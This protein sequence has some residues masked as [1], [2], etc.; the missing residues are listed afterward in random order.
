MNSSPESSPAV[1]RLQWLDAGIAVV[2]MADRE[3]R[4]RFSE[5]LVQGLCAAF[6]RIEKASETRAVVVHGYDS[7]FCCGGT[8]EELLQLSSGQLQFTAFHYYDL[9]LR[10]SVP[11]IAAM[12]GH[13]IGG[14]LV[15]GAYA[16]LIVLAE[17]CIYCANFMDYGF[18]PGLGATA[19]IP[20]RFGEL[21][22]H[23][24]LLTAR[25]YH[26]GELRARGAPVR[27]T[28]RAHVIDEALMLARDLATK[29][30]ETLRQLKQAFVSAFRTEQET[31]V[32]RELRMHEVCFAD[33]R[34]RERI[35]T[36]Y[37]R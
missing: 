5:A 25:S 28:P 10:C 19:I 32:Q 18:T 24:M 1:V 27:V 21:L 31:A 23:E 26:G 11:V 30:P 22:G 29:P 14:G 9:L 2:S 17:E 34:V 35:V 13:A 3:S 4:N 33:P 8:L 7:Y 36:H 15:F 16:D 37:Q 20:R 6:E 12:Q